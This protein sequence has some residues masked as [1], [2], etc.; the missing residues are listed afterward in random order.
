MF[1]ESQKRAK[2]T[3]KWSNFF[4]M[5]VADGTG[6]RVIS[7]DSKAVRLSYTDFGIKKNKKTW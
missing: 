1:W 3:G 6:G 2:S 7:S 5:F 4:I